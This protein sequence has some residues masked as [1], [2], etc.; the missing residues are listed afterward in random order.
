M[1]CKREGSFGS[2]ACRQDE[3]QNTSG[4]IDGK[5]AYDILPGMNIMQ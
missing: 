3:F 5:T 1:L 2:Q 4:I